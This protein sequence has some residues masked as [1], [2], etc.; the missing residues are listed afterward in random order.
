[1]D[2]QGEQLLHSRSTAIFEN[3]TLSVARDIL[4]DTF[5][6]LLSGAVASISNAS[7]RDTVKKKEPINVD[8]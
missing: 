3:H 7:T 6:T 2:F 1:L 5:L 4:F 8:M